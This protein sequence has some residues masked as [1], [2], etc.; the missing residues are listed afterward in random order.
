MEKNPDAPLTGNECEEGDRHH[1]TEARPL[2]NVLTVLGG[3]VGANCRLITQHLM[4]SCDT[5]PRIWEIFT[6]KLL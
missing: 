4:H 6:G 3:I 2:R 1:Q 5:P